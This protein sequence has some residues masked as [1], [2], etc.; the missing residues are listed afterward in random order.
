MTIVYCISFNDM[1]MSTR[2]VYPHKADT[3]GRTSGASGAVFQMFA[4]S[5]SFSLYIE[6]IIFNTLIDE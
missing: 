6:H 5:I 1:V 3:V 2:M 4:F